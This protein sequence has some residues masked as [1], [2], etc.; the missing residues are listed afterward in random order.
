MNPGPPGTAPL[1]ASSHTQPEA[2]A[3]QFLERLK[4]PSRLLVAYSGGGDST[5]LL[6]ALSALLP[7]FPGVFLN[8][9]TVDHGLR[10]GSAEE[11]VQAG[12]LCA[13]LGV[14][15]RVLTWA[16]AKPRTGIQAAARE[17]RYR[18]LTEHALREGI[19]FILTGHN[20]DDQ[21]ETFAMRKARDPDAVGGISEAVLVE[22]SVW[23]VRPFLNVGRDDIR[24]YLRQKGIGWIEDP[25]NDNVAFER[26]RVR[27]GLTDAAGDEDLDDAP[28]PDF[29]QAAERI[30]Q[31][32]V[33]HPGLVVEVDLTCL[34]VDDPA[35]RIALL[36]VAALL[37]G[38]GHLAGK[39]T[40]ARIIEF[41]NGADHGRFAAERVVFDR[42]GDTLFIGREARGLSTLAIAPG[43]TAVWDNRF[44]VENTGGSEIA[45]GADGATGTPLLPEPSI[46]LPK[47]VRRRAMDTLPRVHDGERDALRMRIIIPQFEHFLPAP[48]LCLANSLANL[49][50]LEHFP[51]LSLG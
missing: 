49:A 19:D 38:R 10:S 28:A 4:R 42:R 32:M 24:Q 13:A 36:S 21:R 44:H 8:A 35:G 40:A 6:V 5:G 16:G 25:S 2:A 41:L 15:H 3:R 14:P 34:R 22:R 33:L 43:R 7:S 9:A 23:V 12:E 30:R 50:G 27:K 37:G 18:L 26:V 20:L 51:S 29:D 47:S 11:A 1:I 46:S 39:E 31:C 17:A 45:I 48:R